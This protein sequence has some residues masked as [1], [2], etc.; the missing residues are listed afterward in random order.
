MKTL[1]QFITCFFLLTAFT[2]A[3]SPHLESLHTA[4]S[5][6]ESRTEIEPEEAEAIGKAV[7][8]RNVESQRTWRYLWMRITGP[9]IWA[10][11]LLGILTRHLHIK[12]RAPLLMRLHKTFG[13][14]AFSIGT[15]HGILGLFF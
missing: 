12:G 15:I 13:Y 11:M 7:E 8:L 3:Y 4:S 10:F 14:S 1:L 9:L 2:Y 5:A 6:V